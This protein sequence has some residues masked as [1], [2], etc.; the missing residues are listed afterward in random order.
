MVTSRQRARAEFGARTRVCLWM[1]GVR[2]CVAKFRVDQTRISENNA[3]GQSARESPGS[4]PDKL[5]SDV[6]SAYAHRSARVH[7]REC[8]RADV[9]VRGA[10]WIRDR[11]DTNQ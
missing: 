6:P 11:L 5:N 8:A 2:M 10:Q 3:M 4:S 9:S 1:F 7:V